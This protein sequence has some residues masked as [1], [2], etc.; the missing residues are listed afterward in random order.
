VECAGS[1]KS[2]QYSHICGC[3]QGQGDGRRRWGKLAICKGSGADEDDSIR[4]FCELDT[5]IF[6]FDK[7]G[8][9]AVMRLGQ[10]SHDLEHHGHEETL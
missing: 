7:D 10:V 3:G 4:E 8:N 2:S 6:M 1:C 5:P 9:F